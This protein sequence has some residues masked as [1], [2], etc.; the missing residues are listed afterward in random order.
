MIVAAIVIVVLAM[1]A[2]W[3]VRAIERLRERRRHRCVRRIAAFIASPRTFD[4]ER[5]LRIGRGTTLRTI[6][7]A[8]AY[9]ADHF[10]PA[11]EQ[12][13]TMVVKFYGVDFYLIEQIRRRNESDARIILSKIPLSRDAKQ[14]IAN[15]KEIFATS[16][17]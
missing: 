5:L 14:A 17:S 4:V 12:R 16:R 11:L 15:S 7:E 3:V 6:A 1:V 10:H 13:L 9:I 2:I 8:V